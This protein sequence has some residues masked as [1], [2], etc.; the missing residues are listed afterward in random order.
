MRYLVV[1]SGEFSASPVN[2]KS[3]LEVWD[4][5]LLI[6]NFVAGLLILTQLLNPDPAHFV[7]GFQDANK[8]LVFLF[9]FY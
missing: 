9:V 8:K 6:P 3:F 2:L 4:D 1:L 5:P 7:T